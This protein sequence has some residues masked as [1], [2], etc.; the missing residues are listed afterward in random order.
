MQTEQKN[1]E[2][3]QGIENEVIQEESKNWYQKYFPKWYQNMGIKS[4]LISLFVILL[5]VLSG[6][7]AAFYYAK[8][9][10]M[11][12]I[13]EIA[14][15]GVFSLL[16]YL[17]PKTDIWKKFMNWLLIKYKNWKI[18]GIM[19]LLSAVVFLVDFKSMI[20]Q[21][22]PYVSEKVVGN[23][24]DVTYVYIMFWLYSHLF[25]QHSWM[26]YAK[27]IVLVI[28]LLLFRALF[29]HTISAGVEQLLNGVVLFIMVLMFVTYIYENIFVRNKQEQKRIGFVLQIVFFATLVFSPY[30]TS[31]WIA[32]ERMDT[33]HFEKLEKLPDTKYDVPVDEK[34]ANIWIDQKNQQNSAT[35]IPDPILYKGNFVFMA[36]SYS[37]N[38]WDYY[39]PFMQE[40]TQSV[41][42]LLTDNWNMKI[43]TKNNHA[44]Y[45]D[46]LMYGHH[47]HAAVA[48]RF[49]PVEYF[50]DTTENTIKFR[51][52]NNSFYT[53]DLVSTLSSYLTPYSIPKA[54][55]VIKDSD[56]GYNFLF[57]AGEKLEL[58]DAAEQ[59][60]FLKGQQIIPLNVVKEVAESSQLLSGLLKYA[61]NQDILI[62]DED[63]FQNVIIERLYTSIDGK[64]GVYAHVQLVA[65][66]R[67]GSRIVN[68]KKSK[69]KSK[70]VDVLQSWFI[71]LFYTG[72]DKL[73]VYYF[74]NKTKD[75]TYPAMSRI[76]SSILGGV[77]STGYEVFGKTSVIRNGNYY[78]LASRVKVNDGVYSMT[79]NFVLYSFKTNKQYP[80]ANPTE[81]EKV[82]KNELS[83]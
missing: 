27:H 17:V 5:V 59:Y 66:T 21:A 47:S 78:V 43:K 62:P 56:K 65:K 57:G 23:F 38:F 35:T 67:G 52:E 2:E 42:I 48:K 22:A 73:T 32:K 4:K 8:M 10:I 19:T 29:Q 13:P 80:V 74:D 75:Y 18:L 16:V 40:P 14:G 69:K 39:V 34:L 71:P 41:K 3:T 72:D 50:M 82:I 54:I 55:Y 64:Q 15:I 63:K 81:M 9:F 31:T 51:D 36:D 49:G 33:I 6:G 44:I 58:K 37:T 70:G 46:D 20:L 83:H 24:V 76:D 79:P 7:Y 77:F 26:K 60:D 1:P 30:L 61:K 68:G 53:V 25:T 12:H 45:S 28:L 11:E